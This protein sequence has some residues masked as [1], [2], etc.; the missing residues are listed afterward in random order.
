M[1]V[2]VIGTGRLGASL[3][4][5]LPAPAF[6]IAALYDKNRAAAVRCRRRSGRGR[7]MKSAV[8]AARAAEV[9]LLCVPDADINAAANELGR[10][11]LN[12]K[13]KIVLHTSGAL[14]SKAL[15]PLGRAGA[16]T[17][18]FHPAQSFAGPDAPPSRF[19]G[20]S[21]AVEGAPKAVAFGRSLALSLGGRPFRLRAEDKPLYHAA[22]SMA[23]NL[24]V[25]LFDLACGLLEET[26]LKAQAAVKILLPLVEGTVRNLENPDRRAALTGPIARGD[27]DTL[28]LHLDIL[29]RHP[30]PGQVYRI[31]GR[32]ALELAAAGGLEA[33]KVRILARRLAGK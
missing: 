18:S 14:S 22:C 12:W 17:G 10:T 6:E 1:K 28:K 29:R 4:R 25:P 15:A 19:R 23:S 13:G 5:A 8:E 26:G 16:A 3:V 11:A 27:A 7:V 24:L 32:R 21:F 9:I 20:A 33:E 31:L 2:A 30:V